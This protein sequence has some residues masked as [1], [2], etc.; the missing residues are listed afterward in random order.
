MASVTW[1]SSNSNAP[2]ATL[3]ITQ[4][5]QSVN[6]NTSRLLYELILYRPLS[7][8]SSASKSY[9]IYVNGSKVAS[10]STTI[11]G[12]GRKEI[13]S[14]YITVGHNA[15]GTKTVSFSFSLQMDITFSGSWI[16]TVSGSTSTSLTTIPRKSSLSAGNGTLGVTQNLTISRASSS[17]WHTI[18]YKCG[19]YSGTLADANMTNA[20]T[21]SFTPGYTL[22]N[23]NTTGTSVSITLTLYTYNGRNGTLLGSVSKTIT[24]SIPS[25]V[26]PAISSV[27]VGSN[28]NADLTTYNG[29]I[30]NRTKATF[31][32]SAS[33]A[34]GS[35][36]ASYKVVLN[37]STYNSSSNSITSNVLTTAGSLTATITVTD[38]RGR[39][40]ST[41][42]TLTVLDYTNPVIQVMQLARCDEYGVESNDDTASHC[43]L[44]YKFVTTVLNNNNSVSYSYAYKKTTDSN[45][46]TV[47]ITFNTYTQEGSVVFAAA[48]DYSYNVRLIVEDDFK[49]V[50]KAMNL[51]SANTIMNWLANGLGMAIGKVAELS[52]YLE[53]GYKTMFKDSIS[54]DAY[55]DA[56]KN[57]YYINNA[58]REERTFESDGVYPHHFS[59]YGASGASKIGLGLYDE[60]HQERYLAC[61]DYDRA[62]ILGRPT[63]FHDEPFFESNALP[64]GSILSMS[65][66]YICNEGYIY[67]W[68]AFVCFYV[69]LRSTSDIGSGNIANIKL[70]N[71][72]AKYRPIYAMSLSSGNSGPICVGQ[73]NTNGDVY[74]SATQSSITAS[75][76]TTS[77]C[78]A[79]CWLSNFTT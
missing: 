47:P 10:G 54:M 64:N 28:P 44:T 53:I 66:G 37:G 49:T 18:T 11:G 12:S 74:L 72:A 23:T 3:Y 7:V 60:L 34:Y 15:D 68:G 40:A 8:S 79:G 38:K 42:R 33:I 32:I 62:L 5:S 14:G 50:T 39:S 41:T 59:M 20:T 29:Y 1:R 46:T 4:D 58:C 48:T 65:S 30:K 13:K 25:D 45:Y 19:S 24:A 52:G 73:V 35:A 31:N 70:G 26:K 76:S 22:A 77:F 6:D 78:L 9:S 57:F 71:L 21:I 17:F 43:K 75:T 16:G 2:Y 36:I 67:K 55:S 56:E 69:Y 63:Y 51:S 27:T 61:D